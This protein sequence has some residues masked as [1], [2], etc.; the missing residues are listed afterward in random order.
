LSPWSLSQLSLADLAE[1]ELTL[2]K[3]TLTELTMTQLMPELALQRELLAQLCNLRLLNVSGREGIDPALR[4]HA[5]PCS[6]MPLLANKS[7]LLR[8]GRG[9]RIDAEG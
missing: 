8:E 3:L 2:V 4:I 6:L 9:Y 7:T 5:E 1:S